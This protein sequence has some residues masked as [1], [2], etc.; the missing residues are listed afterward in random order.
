MAL[1]CSPSNCTAVYMKCYW[2]RFQNNLFIRRLASDCRTCYS[3]TRKLSFWRHFCHWVHRICPRKC[4]Q[5]GEISTG[6]TGGNQNNNFR[7]KQWGKSWSKWEH[8]RFSVACL[9]LL[10]TTV[11]LDMLTSSN[12]NIFCVTGHLCGELTGHQWNPLTK[13]SDAEL[14][15]FLFDL[16]LNKWLSKESWRRCWIWDAIAFIITSLWW[17]IVLG[18]LD[19]V[20]F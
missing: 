3:G 16:R 1:Y 9:S 15:C 8:F 20:W 12:G 14:W 19:E 10:T 13:A 6:S 4:R 17:G 2:S 7:C 5:F 11:F 18:L